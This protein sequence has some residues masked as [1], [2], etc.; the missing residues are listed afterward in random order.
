[1]SVVDQ[2]T[3]TAHRAY[4]DEAARA[5][6]DALVERHLPL[7]KRILRRV[8]AGL[9]SSVDLE[10][11]ESAGILGL[12]Q[13][14]QQF[15]ESLDVDFEKYAARRIEGEIIDELRRNSPLSQRMLTH[16]RLVR[17]AMENIGTRATPE[18]LS[19]LT[20]LT[21]KE[22]QEALAATSAANIWNSDEMDLL[23]CGVLDWQEHRPELP[24]ERAELVEALT[25]ALMSMDEKDRQVITLYYFEE[26][27]LQEI[28]ELI[29]MSE[30]GVSRLRKRL[31]TELGA[32]L[33][34]LM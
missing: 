16:L 7:V 25:K 3:L 9:P 24:V 27:T 23:M 12:L 26:L 5:K 30:S 15:D 29:D 33:R 28:A 21:V 31:V 6:R 1:M 17:K 4:Q 13:A 34:Q 18:E 32:K 20:R 2:R 8:A 11:L 22:V 10:S 14:A 19:A